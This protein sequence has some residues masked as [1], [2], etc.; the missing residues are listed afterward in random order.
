LRLVTIRPLNVT[1]DVFHVRRGCLI[2]NINFAGSS[3]SIAHTGCGAVAFPSTDPADYAVSGYIAPGP[4]NEGST[5][6]WRS[7]YIRN[8]TN[9]MTGSIGMKINGRSCHCLYTRQ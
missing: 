2:E 8:C 6:R 4:A 9:F 5:G 7:P 1:K 3:V